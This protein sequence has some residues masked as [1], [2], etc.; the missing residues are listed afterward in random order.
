MTDIQDTYSAAVENTF[1]LTKKIDLVAGASYDWRVL[2]QAEGWAL[3]DTKTYPTAGNGVYQY[4]TNTLEAFNWQSALTYR[5]SNDAKVYASV[6]DRTRFPTLFELYSLRFGSQ[7]P[8]ASLVPEKATNYEIGWAGKLWNANLSTAVFYS[9]VTN[10]IESVYTNATVPVLNPNGLWVTQSQ[11]VG[12]GHFIGWEGSADVP[13]TSNLM[14]GGNLTLIRRDIV[15]PNDPNF[16]LTG[17]PDA[18]GIFY[19]KMQPVSGLTITPNVEVASTRWT[20]YGVTPTCTKPCTPAQPYSVYYQLG[21][22][23]LANISAD[24][25]FKPGVTLNLTAHNLFDQNYSLVD[26]YPGAGAHLHRSG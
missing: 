23:T 19:V 22:Y 25:E 5:Y 16:E 24:Y 2:Q 21:A 18:K 4:P 6:S 26:G 7:L 17:V 15:N 3:D 11:N 9:D 10:F 13:V 12:N 20:S 8:N 1:H 14:V